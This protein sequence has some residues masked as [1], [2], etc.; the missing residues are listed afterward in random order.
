MVEPYLAAL[1]KAYEAWA[2]SLCAP[3]FWRNTDGQMH[4]GTM[5]FVQTSSG[6]LG[7]TNAH[8]A[9][10]IA[11]CTDEPGRGC[12]LGGADLDPKRFITRHPVHD[13]ATYRLSEVILGPAKHHAATVPS[14]PPTPPRE[15]DVVMYG[16]WPGFLRR[17]EIGSYDFAFVWVAGKVAS[18][19]ERHVGMM[20][21]I[22]TS[23]ALSAERIPPHAD[24]GGWS[25]GPVFRV[26]DENKIERLELA[27]IIYEYSPSFEIAF[28]HPLADLN[29]DGTFAL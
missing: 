24:L 1:L 25:G 27:G 7:V 12:Q 16:G 8:V 11:K 13:L 28:A 9:E 5:T 4:N 14:W 19:H 10:E 21:E 23:K 15:G 18:A 22:E 17:E 2:K 26:V 29:E 6:V 20:L 3:V